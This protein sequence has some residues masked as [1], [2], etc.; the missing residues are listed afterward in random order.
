[1]T[2]THAT[3]GGTVRQRTKA[4]G[5]P[6][7]S[8]PLEV[9]P[10]RYGATASARPVEPEPPLT[11]R[12][13][14][15]TRSPARVEA[16]NITIAWP[17]SCPLTSARVPRVRRAIDR[18]EQ[19][20]PGG[21][22]RRWRDTVADAMELKHGTPRRRHARHRLHAGAQSCGRE[23]LPERCQLR[24]RSFGQIV[25]HAPRVLEHRS[26]ALPR[27]SLSMPAEF[28]MRA[29]TR[30]PRKWLSSD[31]SRPTVTTGPAWSGGGPQSP[32]ALCPL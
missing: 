24:W 28:S 3:A 16:G 25:D 10:R 19:G 4:L 21:R 12:P 5:A 31:A 2:H 8:R 30:Q 17:T 29:A 11:V 26:M 20:E 32:K 18:P 7:T 14:R 15:P 22:V 13:T 9:G 27:S 23:R 1:M 6:L